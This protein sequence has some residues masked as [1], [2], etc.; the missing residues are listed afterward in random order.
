MAT[1]VEGWRENW[2]FSP[3]CFRDLPWHSESEA[4]EGVPVLD[5]GAMLDASRPSARRARLGALREAVTS[6]GFLYLKNHGIAET[7][8]EAIAGTTRSFFG[9]PEAYKRRFDRHAQV[10]GYTSYRFE[11]TARFFGTSRGKDLCMKYTMGPE[12][13]PDQVR[14]RLSS[15]DDVAA[16]A[17]ST[18]LFPDQ[19]FRAA[20]VRYYE[21][22][23][24]VSG[25]LLELL[26]DA[27]DLGTESRRV[28]AE[29]LIERSC[30]ELR[31]LQYPDVPRDACSDVDGNVAD[32]MAAHFDLD[33]VTLLHQTPCKNGFASLEA[34]LDG[35]FVKVPALRGTLVVNLGEVTRLLTGGRVRATLHRVARPPR[36]L[37]RGSARDVTVFF[38][39][40]PLNARLR[41]VLFGSDVGQDTLFD[42]L[43]QAAGAAGSVTFSRLRSRLF[44][45]FMRQNDTADEAHEADAHLF[46]APASDLSRRAVSS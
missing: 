9:E 32:R 24:R 22:V 25:Q 4:P 1:E 13:T 11:S 10:R 3:L 28:W 41:P 33:V 45:E 23:H 29:M 40:P 2:E 16:N 15:E 6:S 17:Y 21:Q 36:H 46:A 42:E 38:Q 8:L 26:G 12:L 18:N 37:H 44:A 27:L 39:A 35:G 14:E 20:W 31:Y 34:E 19:R 30:G 7:D 5:L 43:Y